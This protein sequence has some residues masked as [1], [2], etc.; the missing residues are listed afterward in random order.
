MHVVSCEWPPLNDGT[1]FTD[2]ITQRAGTGQTLLNFYAGK[3]SD[4]AAAMCVLSSFCEEF[5]DLCCSAPTADG[6]S[7]CRASH[8]T[9]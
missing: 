8:A 1:A 4:T 6:T 5:H 2:H 3:H 9:A 7:K